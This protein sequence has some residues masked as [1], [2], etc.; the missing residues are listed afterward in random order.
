MSKVSIRTIDVDEGVMNRSLSEVLADPIPFPELKKVNP[1]QSEQ[2]PRRPILRYHGGKW[3]LGPW[4]ISHFPPHVTYTEAFCGAANVFLQKPRSEAEVLNDLNDDIVNLFRVLRNRVEAAELKR[5]LLLT[6]YSYVEFEQARET[7]ADPIEKARR[8]MILS[9]MSV[10][11]DGTTRNGGS[12]FRNY[13]KVESIGKIPARQW[14][15]FVQN[16]ETITARLEGVIIEHR[17]AEHIL[18]QHDG[19]TTLHYVDPPY[20]HSTR[21]KARGHYAFEMSDD[22]HIRLSGTL[23]ELDGMVVL[24][25]YD[26]PLYADLYSDWMKVERE[27]LADLARPR[28]EALWLNEAAWR[29][30]PQQEFQFA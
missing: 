4:I 21:G 15:G 7:A 23:R 26:S 28:T 14:A 19:T 6:P 3:L 8:M 25:G 12:G 22:D 10:G 17:D 11:S 20:V 16:I 9:F 24:S 2:K 13:S 5:Q 1:V 29:Q 18:R 27:A 30:R